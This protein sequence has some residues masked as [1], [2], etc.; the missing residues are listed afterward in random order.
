VAAARR[1][2]IRG[3]DYVPEMIAQARRALGE[4]ADRLESDVEVIVGDI[5]GLDEPSDKYD[6]V[7]VTRVIINVG[8][9]KRQQQA[10]DEALRVVKPGGVLLLSEACLQTWRSLNRFRGEWGLEPIP[11]PAFNN[12]LDSDRVIEALAP[13]A[14]LVELSHFA[15]SYYVGTRVLKPLLSGTSGARSGQAGSPGYES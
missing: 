9:W 3:I 7:I 4:V 14:S 11:M 1:I 6:K 10:L 15:S 13:S 5:T 8:D 12:Y 2:S